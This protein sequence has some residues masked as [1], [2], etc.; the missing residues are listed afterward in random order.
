MKY[1]LFSHGFGVK[2]DSRGMFTEIAASLPEYKPVMF[3]YNLI[4]SETNETVVEPYSKQSHLL[5]AQLGNIHDDDPNADITLICHSQGCIMPCLLDRLDV[6]K[7]IL[8]APPKLLGSK[9]RQNRRY[10]STDSGD[11]KIPR[12]DG[13]TTIVTKEFLD[14]LERTEPLKLYKQLAESINTSMI[15]AK[16]DE[17]IK[18][19]GFSNVAGQIKIYEIDG[20]HNFSGPDRKGLLQTLSKIL[21]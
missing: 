6:S 5:E 9:N 2:K 10:E 21:N 14:E 8:L 12:K 16:Q 15:I 1:I 3:D 19:T 20:D 7:V 17:I 4:N 11:I 13:S 18:D